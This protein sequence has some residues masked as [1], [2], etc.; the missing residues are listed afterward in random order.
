MGSS[1][2]CLARCTGRGTRPTHGQQQSQQQ[3]RQQK[4]QEQLPVAAAPAPQ[5]TPTAQPVAV[6]W[7]Q[8]CQLRWRQA[9]RLRS[10]Q[11]HRLC[12]H[13]SSCSCSCRTSTLG[14]LGRRASRCRSNISRAPCA[15]GRPTGHSGRC[16]SIRHNMTLGRTPDFAMS[17]KPQGFC[18][19][20]LSNAGSRYRWC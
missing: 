14:M 16:R 1:G 11:A 6:A 5:T 17:E 7:R 12:H 4:R 19:K 9:R 2:C 8:A 3:Y 15:L 10:R 18:A 20:N 13:G